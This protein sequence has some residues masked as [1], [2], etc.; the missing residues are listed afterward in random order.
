MHVYVLNEIKVENRWRRKKIVESNDIKSN[1]QHTQTHVAERQS[2]STTKIRTLKLSSVRMW[3]GRI[4]NWFRI[5]AF[6]SLFTPLRFDWFKLEYILVL[7]LLFSRVR[8]INNVNVYVCVCV[9]TFGV[10]STHTT[11]YVKMFVRSSEWAS[12]NWANDAI[13]LGYMYIR[14]YSNC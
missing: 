2:A 6:Y 14:V 5:I 8:F 3:G 13:H 9:C 1:K 7:L 10:I 12:A 11:S 4:R